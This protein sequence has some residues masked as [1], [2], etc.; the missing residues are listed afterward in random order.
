MRTAGRSVRLSLIRTSSAAVSV[1][2]ARSPRTLAVPLADAGSWLAESRAQIAFGRNAKHGKA[3]GSGRAPG[4]T[5]V[6]PTDHR[7]GDHVAVTDGFACAWFGR[8][9]VE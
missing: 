6:E 7:Y 3:E 4:V 9:L 5:M 8:V 2:D 1:C